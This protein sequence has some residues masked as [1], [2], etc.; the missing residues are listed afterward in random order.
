MQEWYWPLIFYYWFV[1][2]LWSVIKFSFF[3]SFGKQSFITLFLKR[4]CR[5][6]EVEVGHSFNMRIEIPSQPLALVGSYEQI[7]LT[8]VSVS[9]LMCESLVTV[10]VVWLLG[11]KLSFVIGLH[12]S[13]KKPLNR[14]DFTKKLVTNSLFTRRAG[15]NGIF[16]P[17]EMFLKL[18]N[19]LLKLFWND[20]V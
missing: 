9:M 11:R 10:S 17:F 16:E 5:G 15:I 2:F 4:I 7:S 12:C 6:F 1:N 8:I 14:H 20:K 3:H 13:L 18:T 19:R